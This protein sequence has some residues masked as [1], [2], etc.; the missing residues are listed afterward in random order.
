S[1]AL[2]R[3]PALGQFNAGQ[4]LVVLMQGAE[5]RR[6]LDP[7]RL[8]VGRGLNRELHAR[9]ISRL[10]VA[11]AVGE[12]MTCGVCCRPAAERARRPVWSANSE[13][14]EGA[15]VQQDVQVTDE[16]RAAV[17]EMKKSVGQSGQPTRYEV[18]STDIRLF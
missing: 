15:L 3:L 10:D 17:E 5:E 11:L 4:R 13:T 7:C 1:R 16:E 2:R 12:A 18:T 9:R 6:E 14:K 8:E